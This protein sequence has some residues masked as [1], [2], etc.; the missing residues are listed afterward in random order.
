M[1]R[2]EAINTFTDGLNTD[3]NPINTPNTVL[4][5]CLNGTLITYDGNELTL[6]NDKGNYPLKN[7]K[8]KENF[9]PVGVK[10]YGDIIY[11]VSYNP[12]T[13]QT[14]IGS[15]PAPERITDPD[16]FKGNADY[17]V[18]DDENPLEISLPTMW[19]TNLVKADNSLVYTA[20]PPINPSF[21]TAN[22][23]DLVPI[24]E[25]LEVF[26]AGDNKDLT[27]NPGDEYQ[28]VVPEPEEGHEDEELGPFESIQYLVLD[29]DKKTFDIT[30]NVNPNETYNSDGFHYVNW[31]VPGY[32]CVKTKMSDIDEF[33]CGAKIVSPNY[34][35]TNGSAVT[36]LDLYLQIFTTDQNIIEHYTN[37]GFKIIVTITPKTG[38]EVSFEDSFTYDALNSNKI[39]YGN[40][41]TLLSHN[42]NV[43]P[44]CIS[45]N[46]K[47]KFKSDDFITINVIPYFKNDNK[48]VYLDKYEKT[49]SFNL[50]NKVDIEKL[51]IGDT[52]WKY[53]TSDDKLTLKFNTKGVL[54]QSVF[55]EDIKLK[56]NIRRYVTY[57]DTV[58]ST[59]QNTVVGKNR[60]LHNIN[61]PEWDP[62]TETTLSIPF[63]PFPSSGSYDN[64]TFYKEDCY[65]MEIKFVN[66]SD[67]QIGDTIKRVILASELLNDFYDS[68]NNFDDIYFDEWVG[69]YKDHIKN[70]EFVNDITV[71]QTGHSID[72]NP[73]YSENYQNWKNLGN[74]SRSFKYFVDL[75]SNLADEL[76]QEFSYWVN[77]IISVNASYSS[78]LTV[79]TGPLWFNM[80]T[81]LQYGTTI[82]GDDENEFDKYTG[83]FSIPTGSNPT[84][85]AYT[86]T[87]KG[88]FRKEGSGNKTVFD[89]DLTPLNYNKAG[90]GYS[91][92]GF[93]ASRIDPGVTQYHVEYESGERTPKIK[94]F[95]VQESTNFIYVTPS[96]ID[97][98]NIIS[99]DN[100][101]CNFYLQLMNDRNLDYMV[102]GIMLG[103]PSNLTH[104]DGIDGTA[105]R[106]WLYLTYKYGEYNTETAEFNDA[107]LSNWDDNRDGQNNPIFFEE[108]YFYVFKIK[109]SNTNKQKLLFKLIGTTKPES[110]NSA[111]SA[112][113]KFTKYE[114][115]YYG[116]FYSVDTD[117]IYNDNS[118]IDANID[119]VLKRVSW[120]Y[121]NFN[122]L[123]SLHIFNL[124]QLGKTNHISSTSLFTIKNSYSTTFDDIVVP[125]TNS[126]IVIPYES[127][128]QVIDNKLTTVLTE[129]NSINGNVATDIL[130]YNNNRNLLENNKDMLPGVK[131][132][133]NTSE[134][135]AD[136]QTYLNIL[137]NKTFN[138]NLAIIT[139]LVDTTPNAQG[140][141][142]HKTV[143]Y[144]GKYYNPS[145]NTNSTTTTNSESS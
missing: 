75:D 10:E 104:V 57:N 11:I 118:T 42:Y 116:D 143:L 92:M 22:Y 60:A 52:V 21:Y 76:K 93:V 84:T 112:I 29:N 98:V 95:D 53:T 111:L 103:Q 40:G 25:N 96:T 30:D 97:A 19:D 89:Y 105:E 120:N 78:N 35:P 59:D 136:T 102:L 51:K 91:D 46:E 34:I 44:I 86:K 138:N 109:D 23:S 63:V 122:L 28:I 67:N 31:K 131:Y 115:T 26:Y 124:S 55:S 56:Y 65:V 70:L 114:D 20:M 45:N 82:L 33:K 145:A 121:D 87:K 123:N 58:A 129:I 71:N 110:I 43:L 61:I 9:I 15:Y 2:R 94:C 68:R 113:S 73:F 14:Q 130:K 69:K 80:D 135:P 74:S 3:L 39:D 79:P 17:E 5:D 88:K 90:T 134:I 41:E 144:I 99:D 106:D 142:I 38:N 13:E 24:V 12:I 7:C 4:T 128:D 127:I 27:L 107:L 108:A 37:I 132:E 8:L 6:Q 62:M 49:L 137:N 117:T 126:K 85:I 48:Y 16:D 64:N 36:N 125:V 77:A 101:L 100:K 81:R 72:E 1:A 133:I 47:Y 119:C 140:Y 83:K 50:S 141:Y 139:Y 54:E 66:E 18:G 32:L